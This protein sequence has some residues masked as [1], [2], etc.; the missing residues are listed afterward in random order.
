MVNQAE[1]EAESGPKTQAESATTRNIDTKAQDRKTTQVAP[2]EVTTTDIID[3]TVTPIMGAQSKEDIKTQQPTDDSTTAQGPA[4]PDIPER[5]S[6]RKRKPNRHKNK[7]HTNH[8]E[9]R[10]LDNINP[11]SKQ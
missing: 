6:P 1:P 4:N 8:Y 2:T 9:G 11:T 10:K 7:R 3:I 5:K